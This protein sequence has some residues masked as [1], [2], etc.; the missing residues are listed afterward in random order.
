M[1]LIQFSELRSDLCAAK[2]YPQAERKLLRKLD[3]AILVFGCLSCELT[4]LE[5]KA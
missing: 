2:H 3:L 5:E 1:L 4:Y